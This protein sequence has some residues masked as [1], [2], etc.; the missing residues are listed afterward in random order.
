M[1]FVA[2]VVFCLSGNLAQ[3]KC[4]VLS[5]AQTIQQAE[6][7][8]IDD[9]LDQA[10]NLLVQVENWLPCAQKPLD[11]TLVSALW[12]ISAAV[13]YYGGDVQ[14]AR[15]DL[16]RA[17]AIPGAVFRE[18]LGSDLHSLWRRENP[19]LDTQISVSPLPPPHLLTVDGVLRGHSEVALPAGPHWIQVLSGSEVVFQHAI[20]L[21]SGERADVQTGLNAVAGVKS[22]G[23]NR[24][25]PLLW[26][27]FVGGVASLGLYGLAIQKDGQ[28]KRAQT[29]N[30]VASLRD[31]ALGLRNAAVGV[32][33][34]GAASLSLHFFF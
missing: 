30:E 12:Q 10:K 33:V 5:L 24:G 15:V 11:G 18:R 31:E 28:M 34:L 22:K 7:A 16:G 13:A 29:P 3:G 17:K 1:R 23:S 19:V 21:Q 25:T 14:V 4:P 26:S 32:G 9:E 6:S 8:V 20:D 2:L 27:G